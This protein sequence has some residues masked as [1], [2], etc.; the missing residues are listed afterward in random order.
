M[1]SSGCA[2]L[3]AWLLWGGPLAA[4]TPASPPPPPSAEQKT[5]ADKAFAAGNEHLQN[6]RHADALA[7]YRKALALLPNEPAL[8]WNGGMSAFFA[9]EYQTAAE[10]WKRLKV[11]EPGNGSVRAKLI[12]AYQAAGDTKNRDAEHAALLALRKSSAPAGSELAKQ[13]AFC[14]DQFSAGG[15]PVFAYEHYEL[16]GARALRYNFLVLKPDGTTSFRVSLGSYKDTNDI[17]RELGDIKPGQRLFHLDGYYENGRVHKTFAFFTAEPSYDVIKAQV[18]AIL[19]G[20][21]AAL[22]GSKQAAPKP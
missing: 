16:V 3:I 10:L 22:S 2:L 14:R 7:A 1:K 11:V 18:I 13:E 15:Q 5:A 12:Q 20:K 21:K 9:K 19:E 6:K 17:A 4:Q 8:L